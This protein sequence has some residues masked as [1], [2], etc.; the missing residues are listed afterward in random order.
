MYALASGHYFCDYCLQARE[1]FELLSLPVS[2]TLDRHFTLWA[3]SPFAQNLWTEELIFF[4]FD[5][6]S[7]E[8][9]ITHM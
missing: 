2:L 1:I 3:A 5:V 9:K 6:K 7:Q 4:C 8:R